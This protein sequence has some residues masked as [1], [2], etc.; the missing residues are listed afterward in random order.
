MPLSSKRESRI[1]GRPMSG[2]LRALNWDD[3]SFSALMWGGVDPQHPPTMLICPFSK[4]C[5]LHFA[6]SAG[7]SS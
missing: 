5:E 2:S 6:L 1:L 7:V 4:K 3:I